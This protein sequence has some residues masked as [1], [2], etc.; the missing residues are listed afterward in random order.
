MAHPVGSCRRPLGTVQCLGEDAGKRR[1]A[2]A[3]R[4]GEEVGL[5]H[6]LARDR[7]PQG[8]HDGL[9]ADDLVEVLGTVFAVKRRHPAKTTRP[10]SGPGDATSQN[11]NKPV[12]HPSSRAHPGRCVRR[13]LGPGCPAAPG[14]NC[15]ALLPPGPDAVRKLP[16]RGTWP[17]TLA[18]VRPFLE[19]H[20]L[21]EG[22]Q[23]R[24]SGLRVQGTAS[25][26]PSA[27][28]RADRSTACIRSLTGEPLVP[29]APPPC[30]TE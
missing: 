11:A 5:A 23:P 29:R 21:G 6:L 1:L 7:V 12:A 18:L 27:T 15:L 4:P 20:P 8:A 9:L 17:S 13:S 10:G 30:V 2:G 28:G 26:P 24:Y 16:V 25:S 19:R 22:V 3:A 14:R